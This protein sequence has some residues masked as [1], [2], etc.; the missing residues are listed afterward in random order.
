MSEGAQNPTR[1]TE[2]AI[3]VRSYSID[4]RYDADQ[5]T[6]LVRLIFASYF[7]AHSKNAMGWIENELDRI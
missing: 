1:K 3:D 5:N 2:Y 7:S 6:L 4:P